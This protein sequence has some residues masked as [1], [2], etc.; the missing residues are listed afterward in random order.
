MFERR[1][2]PSLPADTMTEK[3]CITL[4]SITSRPTA[5]CGVSQ[6]TEQDI[7][8]ETSRLKDLRVETAAV[9]E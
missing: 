4:L 2:L 6:T 7:G 5:N 1:P 3:P 8:R 9:A